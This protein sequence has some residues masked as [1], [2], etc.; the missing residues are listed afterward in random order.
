MSL[1]CIIDII[2]DACMY[3]WGWFISLFTFQFIL[4]YLRN[5]T[6]FSFCFSFF[7]S[8]LCCVCYVLL[9]WVWRNMQPGVRESDRKFAVLPPP[10]C[11]IAS[12]Q[13]SVTEPKITVFVLARRFFN[14]HYSPAHIHFCYSTKCSAISMS[15]ENVKS[16]THL[17]SLGGYSPLSSL[18]KP[19]FCKKEIIIRNKKKHGK[20]TKTPKPMQTQN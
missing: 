11:V 14:I 9:K 20:H 4:S 18:P 6:S 2:N 8:V 7:L 13:R 15:V 17:C 5:L 3:M 1:T 19:F 16:G 12:K 10:P